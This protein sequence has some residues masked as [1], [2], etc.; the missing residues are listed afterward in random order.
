V[1]ILHFE[2]Y[3]SKDWALEAILQIHYE[4]SDRFLCFQKNLLVGKHYPGLHNPGQNWVAIK[5]R[6]FL[7]YATQ[8]CHVYRVG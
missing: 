4:I 3:L 1:G 5:I 8:F 2:T 6:K 7:V